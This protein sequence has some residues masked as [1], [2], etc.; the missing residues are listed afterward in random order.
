[1]F[2]NITIPGVEIRGRPI[3]RDHHFLGKDDH[4]LTD[5]SPPDDMIF[6]PII[7]LCEAGPLSFV[8]FKDGSP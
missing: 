1:M 6:A 7:V 2:H 8:C 3:V 5:G 4:V